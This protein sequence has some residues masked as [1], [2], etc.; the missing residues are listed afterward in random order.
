VVER[1]A[2]RC[3][4]STKLSIG[5]LIHPLHLN[6]RQKQDLIVF[7]FTLTGDS[8]PAELTADTSKP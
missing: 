1:A 4:S 5:P 6:E 2:V 8:L 7:L 3:S